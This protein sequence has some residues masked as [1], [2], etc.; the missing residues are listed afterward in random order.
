MNIFFRVD[1]SK[2]I[3]IGHFMRCLTIANEMYNLGESCFFIS[4]E[5][6]EH[7]IKLLEKN[8]HG[9]LQLPLHNLPNQTEGELDWLPIS[10]I[11]DAN[12]TLEMLACK[13]PGILILD[14]YGIDKDWIRLIKSATKE[15]IIIDDLANR[16]LDCDLLINP[17]YGMTEEDYLD[18]V[19]ADCKKLIGSKYAPIRD[20]FSQLRSSAIMKRNSSQPIKRILVFLGGGLQTE[21]IR[22]VLDSLKKINWNNEIF[23]DLIVNK[24][25]PIINFI[26]KKQN[27]YP[28]KI[29]IFSNIGN[30]AE[31]ILET[32]LAIGSAGSASWE[33]CCLGLPSIVKVIA[34]NQRLIAE[35]LKKTGAALLWENSDQLINAIEKFKS[36]KSF[37]NRMIKSAFEVCDGLGVKRLCKYI[38]NSFIL[39]TR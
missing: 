20:E 38:N 2:S 14:Q 25:D 1:A 24:D 27:E 34:E 26:T 22:I 30:M 13:E 31:L 39:D 21:N 18:L 7:S 19:N 23:I 11:D 9:Y 8:N 35:N 32:D 5:L 17:T 37:Q 3:G 33:R 15:I 29:N 10:S 36:S 6:S 4:R 12:E 16:E 28:H